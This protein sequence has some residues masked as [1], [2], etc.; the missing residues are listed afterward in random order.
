M[1]QYRLITMKQSLRAV[2]ALILVAG[3]VESA[4]LETT[5]KY[6]AATAIYL[7]AG[8]SQGLQKGDQGEIF[9]GDSAIARIEV[10]FLAENSSSCKII[11]NSSAP[12]VG[13]RVVM[14]ITPVQTVKPDSGTVQ[15]SP[16]VPAPVPRPKSS[17]RV[18]SNR[19]TGRVSVQALNQDDR[20]SSNNDY[21]EPAFALRGQ[22]DNLLGTQHTISVRL[23]SR[24]TD[25]SSMSGEQWTHRVYEF[26]LYYNNPDARVHYSAGRLLSNRMSGIGY[27]DG[28][29]FDYRMN[30]NWTMGLF[31]GAQPDLRTYDVNT[32]ATKGGV[33]AAYERGN[34]S[35]SQLSGTL[36]L[37]GN[38]FTGQISR[39]FM[40]EQVSF[41]EQRLYVYESGEM[42][43]NRG[44]RREAEG[45]SL[46]L[47][48]LLLNARYSPLT[49]LSTTL[50][51]DD[52]RNYRTYETRPAIDSLFD[53]AL[54]QGWRLGTN[55][56]F[57]SKLYASA[58]AGIRT[59]QHEGTE[60]RSASAGVGGYG[61]I[62]PGV[63]SDARIAL[64]ES[65]F[66]RGL[67]PTISLSRSIVPQ[68]RLSLELG[69]NDYT[70]QNSSSKLSNQWMRLNADWNLTRHVYGSLYGEI[71]RGDGLDANRMFG[72]LG[73]RF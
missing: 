50:G 23:R 17:A 48:N 20:T 58:D 2:V 27:L 61:L 7:D 28:A 65:S 6:V 37:A 21:V 68:L 34:Y 45:S 64:F 71:Y 1:M 60:T 13:D 56:R 5:V 46:D 9:H 16:V 14:Q 59:K 39:E 3:V 19:V 26:G 44:W 62:A 41:A 29:M 42:E 22:I 72:E 30:S 66:S 24:K 49:W 36:A 12:Q 11:E 54:R 70:I 33:F 51:F 4:P 69:R 73:Y 38:Y 35:T 31:G 40:Y 10:E 18:K 47:S 67:Q 63:Q 52:R 8:N 32:D 53:D 43:I 15:P 57:S 25:R 55:V